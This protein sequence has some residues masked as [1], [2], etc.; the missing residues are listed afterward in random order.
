VQAGV[1]YELVLPGRALESSAAATAKV[2]DEEER[3]LHDAERR[4]LIEQGWYR[5][6]EI[7]RTPYP[8]YD[9]NTGH[10]LYTTYSSVGKRRGLTWEYQFIPLAL[11]AGCARKLMTLQDFVEDFEKYTL[12]ADHPLA[13]V[14]R[15]I[16]QEVSKH[17]E[18]GRHALQLPQ[19]PA[20]SFKQAPAPMCTPLPLGFDLV[21]RVRN[22][23]LHRS[24]SRGFQGLLDGPAAWAWANAAKTAGL[25]ASFFPASSFNAMCPLRSLFLRLLL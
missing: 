13:P 16:E 11:M 20:L 4:Q 3:H 2:T 6:E 9:P 17:G 12:S 8:V 1:G 19:D 14:Q 7:T 15:A 22:R 23:Y 25:T 24:A 5:E 18:R 10:L 21:Q